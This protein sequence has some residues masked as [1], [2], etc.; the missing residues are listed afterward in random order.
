MGKRRVRVCL[1]SFK[2]WVVVLADDAAYSKAIGSKVL[3]F[4]CQAPP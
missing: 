3:C 4:N 1:D 2:E